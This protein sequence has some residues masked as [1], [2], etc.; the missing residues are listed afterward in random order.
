MTKVATVLRLGRERCNADEIAFALEMRLDHVR[1]I[2]RAGWWP[3][4]LPMAARR[5]L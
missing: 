5:R 1:R 4:R 3:W 2:L